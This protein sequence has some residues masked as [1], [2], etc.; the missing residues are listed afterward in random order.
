LELIAGVRAFLDPVEAIGEGGQGVLAKVL[1]DEVQIVGGPALGDDS[2]PPDEFGRASEFCRVAAVWDP[3]VTS[4]W[5][6]K[7]SQEVPR[8][9]ALPLDAVGVVWER[10]SAVVGVV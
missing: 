4:S 2:V 10:C 5:R 9:V 6:L 1:L 8:G 3:W 7:V